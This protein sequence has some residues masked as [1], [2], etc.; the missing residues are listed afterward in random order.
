MVSIVAI[1]P[2]TGGENDTFD[3]SVQDIRKYQVGD[4]VEITITGC[5]GMVSI[6]PEPGFGNP[7][8]GVKVTDQ[9]IKV[10][11]NLQVEG[12]QALIDG[13]AD[14]NADGEGEDY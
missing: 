14:D 5:I 1:K 13:P 4:E 3:V 7:K 11:G 2:S 9:V 12:I 10:T 8:I 6:P